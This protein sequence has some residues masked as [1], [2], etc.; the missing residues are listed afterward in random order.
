MILST[1]KTGN[2]WLRHLLA[3]VYRLPQFYLPP[4]FDRASL[5][6]AGSRWVTH[7]HIRPNPLL[8]DWIR[9][10]R[11]VVITTIRHPGDV[12]ISLYHHVHRF[13]AAAL[14]PEF[15]RR[16]LLEGF[17]RTGVTTDSGSR[18]FSADLA[19]SIEWMGC[20]GTHVVRY[21]DLRADTTGTLRQ[22]TSRIF[23]ATGERIAAAIE[24]CELDQMR[25]MAG[26]FGGFFR[27]GRLG[28]WRDELP[29][30]TA[31][32]LRGHEPYASQLAALGYSM[33]PAGPLNAARVQPRQTHPMATVERFENGVRVSPLLIQCLFWAPD[34]LRARWENQFQGAAPASFYEWLNAPC[35]ACGRGIYEG[36]SVSNLAA[37]LYDWR[38]DVRLAYPDLTSRSR[39]E[40]LQWFLRYAKPVYNLDAA[41]ID[42][43]RG[44]LLRW[45]N[46]TTPIDGAPGVR[47]TNFVLHICRT[48]TNVLA[49]Y[50]HIRGRDR[51]ALVRSVFKAARSLRMDPEYVHALEESLGRH[52]LPSGV[53]RRLGLYE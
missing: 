34:E 52:W 18:P 24:M 37:F 14:D 2:T 20:E 15:L 19:C 36:L 28:A 9:E 17:E 11:P 1:P 47:A 45:A 51:R 27:E 42:A 6:R 26:D 39:Y 53:L 41:F 35:P 44:D 16:M 5:D 12:L 8:T 50:P 7:Y 31:D 49:H 21:E 48:R 25:K 29:Q 23:P 43:V 13:R 32:I 46:A 10:E 3:G 4:D 38:P 22:L 40:Y 33:D 30:E